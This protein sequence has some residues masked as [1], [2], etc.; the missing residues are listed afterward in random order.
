[1][2][3]GAPLRSGSH[4]PR[5]LLELEEELD[6]LSE[7]EELEELL[8]LEEEVSEPDWLFEDEESEELEELLEEALEPSEELRTLPEAFMEQAYSPGSRASSN[9][10]R[11]S[12]MAPNHSPKDARL[13][14]GFP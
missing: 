7:D 6:E 5:S 12:F 3:S 11:L 2:L 13:I 9:K 8:E 10:R 1:M 14:E 4:L